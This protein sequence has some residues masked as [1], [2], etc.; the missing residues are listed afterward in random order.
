MN[1]AVETTTVQP[2]V[3]EA[4]TGF[5]LPTNDPVLLFFGAP[6]PPG[7]PIEYPW[8]PGSTHYIETPAAY[9]YQSFQ[10]FN[11]TSNTTSTVVIILG[12]VLAALVALC[13]CA[14]VYSVVGKDLEGKRR[15]S[16]GVWES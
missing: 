15:R 2:A 5:P 9:T 4:P 7:W 6:V 11:R 12:V 10:S 1:Q 3:T 8:P 14:V 13:A 16:G